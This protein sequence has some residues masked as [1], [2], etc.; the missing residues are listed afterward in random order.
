MGISG[1]GA[2]APAPSSG[3]AQPDR[4]ARVTK[5][6]ISPGQG[7]LWVQVPPPQF[8]APWAQKTLP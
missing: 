3:V 8:A 6:G 7:R 1:S 4:A 2:S 5:G